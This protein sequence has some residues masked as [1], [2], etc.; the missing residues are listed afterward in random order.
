MRKRTRSAQVIAFLN[1]R[2]IVDEQAF[3][4][5]NGRSSAPKKS[6]A[7]SAVH[8]KSKAIK[9]KVAF[10]AHQWGFRPAVAS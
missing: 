7:K 1:S 4:A 9:K 10:Q 5:K 3:V 2:A 6:K 8:K